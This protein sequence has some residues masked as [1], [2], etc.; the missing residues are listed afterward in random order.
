MGV[1]RLLNPSD[2]KRCPRSG[3]TRLDE[4]ERWPPKK[5]GWWKFL[6]TKLYMII[7][8]IFS[9]LL[10]T[11]IGVLNSLE[12]WIECNWVE[13]C[14][15]SRWVVYFLEASCLRGAGSRGDCSKHCCSR[16]RRANASL[17]WHRPQCVCLLGM[18]IVA[19]KS[20]EM[21]CVQPIPS[22]SETY[23]FQWGGDVNV[24]ATVWYLR[25]GLSVHLKSILQSAKMVD[26]VLVC[27][28]NV[29]SYYF[30]RFVL[31]CDFHC[32]VT[33]VVQR[34]KATQPDIEVE[35]KAV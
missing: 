8:C 24:P 1:A 21:H 14:I 29:E 13:S 31:S 19:K 23:M 20:D 6:Y 9:S 32:S 15:S 25:V 16:S 28:S 4:N 30:S 22:S 3:P 33:Q 7:I 5:S 35:D 18:V 34:H 17:C 27:L 11:N 12:R 2:P 10:E 26:I